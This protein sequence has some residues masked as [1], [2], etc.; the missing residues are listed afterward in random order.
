VALIKNL[1]LLSQLH[2]IDSLT[3][4]S[5]LEFW[6]GGYEVIY[7]DQVDGFRFLEE[8]T[9]VF[10]QL[11][12]DDP[13]GRLAPRGVLRYERRQD[14]SLIFSYENEMFEV[15]AFVDIAERLP[16][17]VTVPS[18]DINFNSNIFINLIITVRDS[19][20]FNIYHFADRHNDDHVGTVFTEI[21]EDGRLR[22]LT[23]SQFFEWVADH[24]RNTETSRR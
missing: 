23:H 8:Y 2:T 14:C 3:G 7:Y 6:G 17:T 24:I 21:Q 19:E 10:W 5:L 4:R 15:F 11:D 20:A 18:G 22:I 12:V 13:V 16:Q 1:C 9:F